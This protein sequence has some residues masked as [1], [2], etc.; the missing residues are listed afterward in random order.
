M[1][2]A[3]WTAAGA[4]LLAGLQLVLASR[5]D[6]GALTLAVAAAAVVLAAPGTPLLA[7]LITATGVLVALAWARAA[8][9]RT[10]RPGL[11]A[12]ALALCLP[13]ATHSWWVEAL[14]PGIPLDKLQAVLLVPCALVAGLGLVLS[15]EQLPPSRRRRRRPHRKISVPVEE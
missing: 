3:E 11:G 15:L 14:S 13:G 4:V 8:T 9:H 5:R 2:P 10:A 6:L 7:G 12:A 1:S